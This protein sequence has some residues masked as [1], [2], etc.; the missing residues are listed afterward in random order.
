MKKIGFETKQ[1]IQLAILDGLSYHEIQSK[2]HVSS[3]F[4]AKMKTELFE[5]AEG[6]HCDSHDDARPCPNCQFAHYQENVLGNGCTAYDCDFIPKYDRDLNELPR[7]I[8]HDS[9]SWRFE[10]RIETE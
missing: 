8:K 10:I 5:T 9:A 7:R 1:G 4:I 2:F 3:S 6:Y